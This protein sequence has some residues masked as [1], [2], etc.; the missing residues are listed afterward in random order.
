MT[1]AAIIICGNRDV[2]NQAYPLIYQW[3]RDNLV[4][5]TLVISGDAPGVDTLAAD[6]AIALSLPLAR[7]PYFSHLGRAGGPARNK[8]MATILAGL[9]ALGWQVKVVG[10]GYDFGPGRGT[11]DMLARARKM[12]IPTKTYKLPSRTIT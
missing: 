6:A 4:K 11:S 2:S 12:K 3:M 1:E 10:F 8:T 5:G 9:R 7:V